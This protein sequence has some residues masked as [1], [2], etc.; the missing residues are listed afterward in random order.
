MDICLHLSLGNPTHATI[1][2]W[3]KK[4]GAGNFRE[5][6]FFYAQKWIL[7]A[8]ESIQFGN[9]K[10]LFVIVVPVKMEDES[11]CL[12]YKDITPLLIKVASS[13]KAEDIAAV[14]KKSID[15]EQVEYA[16]SDLGNNLKKAF[17]ILNIKHIEDINHKFS[18]M[19]QKLFENDE[20]FTNYTKKLSEMRAKL[21]LSK[22]AR[23]VPPNQRVMSRYM[24]LT[25]L[26]KWGVN[27]IKLLENNHLTDEECKIL[28]FLPQNKTFVFETYELL[29]TMNQIQKVMKKNGMSRSTIT[30]ALQLL[31]TQNNDN[32][33][34]IKSMFMDYVNIMQIRMGKCARII[35]SS[36][37]IE[38][39]FGKY[40]ELVK[41][42]KTVG[43]SDLALCISAM[44]GNNNDIKKQFEAV[45]T[46]QVN[47]WKNENIGETLFSE[48]MKLM[49]IVA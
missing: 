9:K 17:N 19:M 36:D 11:N 21:S 20:T 2:L 10:L 31:D 12:K 28:D 35:C 44:L 39:C 38:S 22:Y 14:I 43:I 41:T 45:S 42:N 3:T 37:I 26:F 6:E 23:I 4:Q 33:I 46:K 15:I 8:D 1:L 5:K 29:C 40:K 13:W 30:N 18:W 34:K 7:I 32:E 49:K 25:P 16:V 48:K 47:E 27:M 24:N